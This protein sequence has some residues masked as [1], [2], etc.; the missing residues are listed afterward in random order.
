MWK[1]IKALNPFESGNYHPWM[2]EELEAVKVE[3]DQWKRKNHCYFVEVEELKKELA[4][5]RQRDTVP[6]KVPAGVPD[7]DELAVMAEHTWLNG[8]GDN[9]DRYMRMTAAIRDAVLRGMGAEPERE[10]WIG[11]PEPNSDDVAAVYDEDDATFSHVLYE[12]IKNTP[13]PTALERRTMMAHCTAM[14]R[15]YHKALS[16]QYPT[17][18]EPTDPEVEALNNDSVR[19]DLTDEQRDEANTLFDAYEKATNSQA[20]TDEQAPAATQCQ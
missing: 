10:E 3:R 13:R 7:V 15:A 1:W 4:A 8:S 17:P 2:R 6:V 5:L 16:N 18:R 19:F 12:M 20:P 9:A 14:W 11:D